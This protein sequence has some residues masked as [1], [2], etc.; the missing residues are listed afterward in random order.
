MRTSIV[1][2]VTG[3]LCGC[4]INAE[5]PRLGVPPPSV[6]GSNDVQGAPLSVPGAGMGVG[7]GTTATPASS[8]LN[9]GN[10]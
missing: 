3:L 1:M 7:A 9:N 6:Q 8:Q 2:L 5:G 10:E 4:T